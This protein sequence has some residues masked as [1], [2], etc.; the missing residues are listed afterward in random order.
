MKNNDY[1][2]LEQRFA[3]ISKLDGVCALIGWDARVCA[4]SAATEDQ[5]EQMA[6]L[7]R[8]RHEILTRDDWDVLFERLEKNNDLD[9]WRRANV[10]EAKRE[11][12]LESALPDDLVARS[13]VASNRGQSVWTK[14]KAEN[15]FKTF[16]P[17]LKELVAI[18]R[19]TAVCI[20]ERT[21]AAPYDALLEMFQP[22]MN[23]AKLDVLFAE[24]KGFLPDFIENVRLRQKKA[25]EPFGDSYP[26]E[27]Q[28]AF[29][30]ELMRAMGFDFDRGR[31]DMRDSA[32]QTSCGRD[33]M[34][35][36]GRLSENNPLRTVAAVMHETGHALYEQG[37]PREYMSQPVGKALGMAAHESQSL[38]MEGFV[39]QN[40]AFLRWLSEKMTRFYHTDECSCDRLKKMS[41]RVEPSLIRIDA[42]GVTYPLHVIVRYELEKDLI[43]GALDVDDLPEAWNVKM[44]EYLGVVPK[45]DAEGCLQDIHWAA[46]SFGYFP[47]YTVGAVAAAQFFAAARAAV[48]DLDERLGKGDFSALKTWLNNNVHALGSKFVFDEWIRRATGTELS[49]RAFKD[50]LRER[51]GV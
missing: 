44:R 15:D 23:V 31:L 32:F 40:D 4:P 34:R 7:S 12:E 27:K 36:V 28:T 24:L 9:D 19:E 21:K 39:L 17:C 5:G 16:A 33:D 6:M 20:G 25:P 46:G 14:A 10:R 18:A 50:A 26:V 2:E 8:R 42:D 37:L 35:V 43:G 47:D 3:E 30:G 49:A 48:P 51:Y 29:C 1:A 22:G 38:L 45:T 11:R 41:R 13:A